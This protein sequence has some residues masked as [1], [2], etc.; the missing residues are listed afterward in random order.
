MTVTLPYSDASIISAKLGDSS[1]LFNKAKAVRGYDVTVP[2]EKMGKMDAGQREIDLVWTMPL[3]KLEKAPYGYR[4]ELA[5]LIPVG[6]YKLTIVLDEGCGYVF[7]KDPSRSEFMAFYQDGV[8]ET[9]QEPKSYFGS[10][11]IPVKPVNQQ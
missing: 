4:A 9:S 3:D 2:M 10:C 8:G 11:G 7:S 1:L 6:M 5:G